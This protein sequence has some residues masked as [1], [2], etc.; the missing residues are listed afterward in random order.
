MANNKIFS[1]DRLIKIISSL[2]KRKK[3]IVFTNGC[4]DILHVGHTAYLNKTKSLGDFLVVG[5]NS[6]SS[7]KSIKGKKRPL[8]PLK[9]RMEILASLECVDYICA[10]SDKTPLNLIKKIRPDV[11]VKGG[12]WQNKEIVG[13]DF[14]KGYGGKI[15]TIPFRKGHS[16][17]G[18]IKK[19]S[20]LQK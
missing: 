9:E 5:V 1:I 11:L 8:N 17:S 13:A 4:F 14:V 20:S 18:L 3:R 16:T 19:I 10:F 7:V 12:D 2:K 15:F 6:D